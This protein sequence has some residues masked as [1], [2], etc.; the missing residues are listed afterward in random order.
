ML[1]LYNINKKELQG[2]KYA[3]KILKRFNSFFFL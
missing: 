3:A 2:Q 1:M